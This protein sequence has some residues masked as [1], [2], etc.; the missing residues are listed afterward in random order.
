MIR[1]VSAPRLDG[2]PRAERLRQDHAHAR[3]RR[4][5]ARRRRQ[6]GR[7]RPPPGSVALRR[8]V[9]YVTQSP[10][11]YGDLTVDENLRYFAR[12]RR[13]PPGRA[14]TRSLAVGR[15]A[16]TRRGPARRARSP[17]ASAPGLARDR[18]ARRPEAAR[19]RR[20]DRRARPGAARASSGTMF[21]EPRRRRDDAARLQPRDGRGRALRRAAPD[22]R[23]R[24]P[25][26]STTPDGICAPTPASTD[27]DAAFLASS[28]SSRTGERSRLTLPPLRACCAQ[29]GVTRARSR[30]C[31]SCPRCCSCFSCYELRRPARGLPVDRRAAPRALPVHRACSSSRR[32][33]CCASAR[34]GT[35]ERLM[36]MPLA[37]L[38]L[39]AGYGL[40][41]GALAAVQAI[42]VCLIGFAP[43][44]PRRHRTALARRPACRRQRRARHGARPL[45]Q[46]F[47]R[48]EFQAVQF[49][50]AVRPA[51]DAALR[52]VR[53]ARPDGACAAV[54]LAASCRSPTPTTRS[55]GV[56]EP[57]G[58]ARR[59]PGGRRR[60]DPPPRRRSARSR[61][62]R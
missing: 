45:L 9:G 47:A 12:D 17:A 56:T 36:T 5:A 53:P 16:S 44:R 50:P 11:V 42:V 41:F 59:R 49:M 22:A 24:D 40:A 37:K 46:R 48:T 23:G 52:S 3:H 54:R 26:A 25:R 8:R 7:A 18:A 19:P 13:A 28:R 29:F 20:A 43:A 33:P 35:L 27:L 38:D 14:S 15:A 51:A 30:C 58:P 61:S 55:H 6:R 34:P 60:C 57:A 21:R 4:R 1:G 39:L 2:P 32:S 10:S 62:Q 31:S